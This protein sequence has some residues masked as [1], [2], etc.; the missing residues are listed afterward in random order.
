MAHAACAVREHIPPQAVATAYS[1][2]RGK[3]VPPKP[4]AADPVWLGSMLLVT[5]KVLVRRALEE[6]TLQTPVQAAD[7]A[8]QGGVLG[9]CPARHVDFVLKGSTL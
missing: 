5:V 8:M 6:S 9:L 4:R 3:A 1:A 7:C 2:S